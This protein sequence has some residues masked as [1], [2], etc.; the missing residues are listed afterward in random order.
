MTDPIADFVTRIRNAGAANKATCDAQHSKIKEQIARILKECGFIKGYK[1]TEE[2]KKR[3]ITVDIKY[4]DGVSAITEI[5][6]YSRP[7]RRTYYK[8]A[9]LPK[10]LGGLGAGIVTTSKG[11]MTDREA[12]SQNIGGELLCKVW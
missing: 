6:R 12:R 10:V 3:F 4:V 1:V 2:G 8:A 7:G 9:D 5:Q 11:L